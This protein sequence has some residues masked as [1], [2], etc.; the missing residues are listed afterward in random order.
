[1][2]G[3]RM[4]LF[5]LT[6][7]VVYGLLNYYIF[8]RGWQAIAGIGLP[9][10][11]ATFIVL[12]VFFN[13]SYFIARMAGK[14]LP[15]GVTDFFAF[16]GGMWFAGMLYFMLLI[17]SFDI[18][19]V[20]GNSLS[21]FPDLLK[22]NWQ[23]VKIVVFFASLVFVISIIT[24]G[25]INAQK[26]KIKNLT[27]DIPKPANGAKDLHLVFASDIHLGHV[28]DR[29]FLQQIVDSINNLKPDII[30]FPGDIVDEELHPVVD[31]NLGELFTQLKAPL[32]IFAV[33]GNHEY[34]G[35]AEPAVK[36]LSQ[37]GITFIRDSVI[38]IDDSFY[39]AG[40][41]DLMRGTFSGEKRKPLR[42]IL[43]G[44]IDGLPIILMDHQPVSLSEAAENNI[45]LQISGHTHH[46]QM[47]PLHLITER[48]F[49]LSWGYKKIGNSHFY[50]SSGAGTWGPRVRVGNNPEIVSIKL[51]F[52]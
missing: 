13:F 45:D 5:F 9:G 26:I 6:F 51:R 28:I 27:F 23:T 37:Y 7:F 25:Y 21:I 39:L 8:I 10:I 50:V 49:K 20:V 41:E 2:K 19:R 47:W 44:N 11:K 31:K 1:M 17:I 33:T 4:I 15:S 52:L 34:I 38:K 30:L 43:S 22:N 40:R 42:E 14:F 16:S 3:I 32:G 46:G 29:D 36:Y 24:L 12:F 48:V 35:G 18:I